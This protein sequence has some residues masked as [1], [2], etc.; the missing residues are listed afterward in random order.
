MMY[1][2]LRKKVILSTCI[3]LALSLISCQ[4]E[5]YRLPQDIIGTWLC[6]TI[7]GNIRYN[8][9]ITFYIN[10]YYRDK[11]DV[12]KYDTL[13][14]MWANPSDQEYSDKCF[15]KKNGDGTYSVELQRSKENYIISGAI[16]NIEKDKMIALL[17]SWQKGAICFKRI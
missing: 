10:G 3:F 13:T 11:E 1:S 9:Q 16:Y 6:D 15:V 8:V 14:S 5:E 4:K 12:Y 2:L 7:Q 17:F